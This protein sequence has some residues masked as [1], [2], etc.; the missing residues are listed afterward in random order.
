MIR[1]T[2]TVGEMTEIYLDRLADFILNEIQGNADDLELLTLL[3]NVMVPTS[4]I[5]LC[6]KLRFTS[7]TGRSAGT[8]RL[9]AHL[10][11]ALVG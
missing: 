3:R 6:D 1:M 11:R 2:R 5:G 8:M 7:G 10:G 9:I 4:W